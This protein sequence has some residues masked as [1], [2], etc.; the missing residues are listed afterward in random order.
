MSLLEE[1]A[2]RVEIY[3]IDEAFIDLHGVSHCMSLEQFGH[4]LRDRVRKEAH[5]KV[6]VGIAC[7]RTLAKLANYAASAGLSS[8]AWSI[9]PTARASALLA[10]VPVEEVWGVGRRISQRLRQLGI[11]TALQLAES[12]APLIRKHF[13]VVLERTVR[14]LRGES[15]GSGRGAV[16]EAADRLLALVRQ[17]HRRLS[18]GTSGGVR[19]GGARGGETAQGEAVLPPVAV[20]LRTSPHAADG[21]YYANQASG[22]LLTPTN[23]TREII[24]LATEGLDRIWR[25]GY[26]YIKTGVILSDFFSQGVAQLDLFDEH[27]PQANGE[28]LMKLMD[29]IN[30]RGKGKLWFA[31]QGIVKPGR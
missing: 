26:R 23:D 21:R 8:A 30:Q 12:P 28:R 2:P 16:G 22:Q 29:E 20:F 15:C 31:G 4:Q 6:G 17:P 25:D 7:T 9:F 11:E 19:T 14:E 18:G 5:L 3:S 13:S 1:L 24:R 10:R 27:R